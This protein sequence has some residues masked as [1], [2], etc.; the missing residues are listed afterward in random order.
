MQEDGE[1]QEDEKDNM[2][3]SSKELSGFGTAEKM[4]PEED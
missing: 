4:L 1:V 3:Y 2:I